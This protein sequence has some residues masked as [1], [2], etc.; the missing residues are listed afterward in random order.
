MRPFARAR[1]EFLQN[2][3]ANHRACRWF[4]IF[5]WRTLALHCLPGFFDDL[6]C[7]HERY[8][9]YQQ[10]N[11]RHFVE[12]FPRFTAKG[13]AFCGRSLG[14]GRNFC[15][16]PAQTSATSIGAA[17]SRL[18]RLIRSVRPLL[19]LAALTS[20][21]AHVAGLRFSNGGLRP[22]IASLGLLYGWAWRALSV[23][24]FFSFRIK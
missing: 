18:F 22:S 16:I 6:Y 21:T 3:R 4:A 15:K 1:K 5:K 19:P 8:S 20:L 24:P 11:C 10:S 12:F 14:Q 7:S 23:R 17:Y 9:V 13:C 2:S